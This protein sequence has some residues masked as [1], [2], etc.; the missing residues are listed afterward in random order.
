MWVSTYTA[1]LAAFLTVKNAVAPINNLEDV[2]AS[3]HQVTILDSGSLYEFFKT[4]K[5]QTHRQ[6]WHRIQ[7]DN[8]FARNI[9]EAVQFI[10]EKDERVFICD[11]PV[12]RHIAN[13]PPCDLTTGN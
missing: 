5:Y 13:K 9:N 12:I 7:A 10:R 6:I 3:S 1:N 2:I 11:G 8:S 4:S